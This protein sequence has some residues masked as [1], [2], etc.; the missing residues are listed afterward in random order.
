MKTLINSVITC[1]LIIT[2]V[3]W[4][5]ARIL[6]SHRLRKIS[7]HVGTAPP[8]SYYVSPDGNDY[9]DGSVS[10]P[11]R[12]IQR[13]ANL[14]MPGA[15]VY[16]AP[17]VYDEAIETNVS[18]TASAR[19]R[20]ISDH[21]WGAKLQA[22]G[23]K[24]IWLNQGSYVD[25][26]GFEITGSSDQGILNYGSFVRVMNNYVHDIQIKCQS[27]GAGINHANY[28]ASD[29]ETVGNVI[30]KVGPDPGCE[31]DHGPGIYHANLRG[32]VTNNEVSYAREGIQLWHAATT[33]TISGN[34]LMH[35]RS[36]GILVGA[37]DAPGN[38]TA[39]DCVVSE[40]TSAYNDIGIRE[41]GKTGRNN[42]YLKNSVFANVVNWILQNG[43]SPQ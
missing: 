29:N 33:V 21:K 8:V 20:F 11:F 26:N 16:V 19:I 10:H 22:N 36:A 37:G 41:F 5:G 18:G 34:V 14:V 17:G 4:P 15:A 39:D 13:A 40:N 1:V 27:S 23:V 42:L 30:R 32:K 38:I 6:S 28:G 24:G 2:W 3:Y 7:A 25:I 35:N 31:S 12:S 43:N 9:S